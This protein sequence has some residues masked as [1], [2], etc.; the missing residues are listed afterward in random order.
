MRTRK[1]VVVITGASSGVGRACAERFAARGCAVVLAAR[2]G[3]ALEEVARRCR[4]RGRADALVVVTDVTDAAAV[5]E[6]ARRAVAAYGRID[7]WVNCAAVAAFGSLHSVPPEVF[8]RVL[9]TDV[10][11]CVH[12]ARAALRV[13]REQGT[14]TLVN[15]SSAVGAAPVPLNSAYV[16][17]KS[18]VRA[19][20][21]ALRQELRLDGCRDVHVCT[22]L[23][24]S[25][26]TPFFARAANYSGRAVRPL[27]P[28]YSPERAARRIVR[29]TRA[30]RREAWVGPA[31]G[32]LAWL[33]AALPG[34]TERLLAR[35]MDRHHL[36]RTEGAADSTGNAFRSSP[37]AARH[38]GW[39]GRRRTA[40]R[41]LAA[42]CCAAVLYR[43][44]RAAL[45]PGK[46][47][48]AR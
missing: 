26:D 44:A 6:L 32:A 20:G 41:R 27:A 21:G 14:G 42:V 35:Q 24:A 13:M 33:S 19:L 8:R 38:G 12:G 5:E 25:M 29:L 37:P 40:S 22:V 11:G 7:V 45:R 15:V 43:V 10:M 3:A 23:P 39:H 9:D 46:P 18:A 28:V 48:A 2:R 30:P 16:V 34:T 17:A 36:S 1:R 31:A 4:R 47:G